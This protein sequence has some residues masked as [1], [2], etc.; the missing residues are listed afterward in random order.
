MDSADLGVAMNAGVFEFQ[1][2]HL[3]S[4]WAKVQSGQRLDANDGLAMLSTKDLTSLGR[5]ANHVAEGKNGK[6]VTYVLNRQCNPTNL[7]VL[8]CK[9]CEFARRKGEEGGW[10]MEMD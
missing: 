4:I 8:S 5:M 7:C 6:V 1:D 2:P 10:V 9:F 3:E